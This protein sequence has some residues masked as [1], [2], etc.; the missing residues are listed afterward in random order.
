M[1]LK[2]KVAL[3]TGAAGNR[4]RHR[5]SVRGRRSGRRC[6]RRRPH[7]SGGAGGRVDQSHRTPCGRR[8]GRR[9]APRPGGADVRA[10]L[11]RARA[12]RHPGEQRRDRDDR[13]V[14]RAQRRAMD[15]SRRRQPPW[16]LALLTGVLPPRRRRTAEGG[17]RQHRIDPG[18]QGAPRPHPLRTHQAG[19]RGPHAQHV[20]GDDAAGHPASTASIPG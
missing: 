15:T 17:H 5:G 1:R 9:G 18:R 8:A 2:G 13:A 3:V 20:G 19:A 6:R 10:G 14:P 11:E 4:P 12:H 16:R 7:E